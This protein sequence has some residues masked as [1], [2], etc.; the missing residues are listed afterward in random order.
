MRLLCWVLGVLAS[1]GLVLAQNLQMDAPKPL[2]T[3]K[4]LA[5]PWLIT[6]VFLVAT[7]VVAFKPAK[8]SKLE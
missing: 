2:G 7:L 4:S 5:I 3:E 1:T 8:R 6:A